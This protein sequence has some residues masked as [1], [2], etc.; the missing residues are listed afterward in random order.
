M[1]V[2]KLHREAMRFNDLAIIT[3]NEN[4]R[5]AYKYFKKAF[6]YEHRAF[7]KYCSS[8]N[9][10]PTRSI[11]ARSSA[12]LA[13]MANLLNEAESL[14]NLGLEGSPSK[15]LETE[16]Q[17]ILKEVHI[18]RLHKNLFDKTPNTRISLKSSQDTETVMIKDIIRCEYKEKLTHFYLSDN[19]VLT[20]FRPLK[21]FQDL[22]N[23]LGFFRISFY[24]LININHVKK[25]QKRKGKG[26]LIMSDS[27]EIELKGKNIKILDKKINSLLKN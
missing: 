22:L 27:S 7:L 25:Y 20:D 10:E 11:L 12:N 4:P 6:E 16:L 8:Q 3:K 17:E 24:T 9:Q 1:T 13:L 19:R 15:E 23:D 21:Q 26:F 5:L 2:K 14:A 18:I